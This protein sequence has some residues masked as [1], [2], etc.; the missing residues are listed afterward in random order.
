M[1]IF[2][3]ILWLIT[4]VFLFISFKRDGA[5]T[6]KA[7]KMALNMGKGMAISIF[8]IIL[9]I[10][11][12][13]TFL[14]PYRNCKLCKQA[15]S[16]SGN[17]WFGFTWNNYHH[18]SIYSLSFDRNF[19]RCRSRYCPFSGFLDYSYHGWTCYISTGKKGVWY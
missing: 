14:P 19:S 4:L 17:C 6:K 13:L 1:D 15:V 5:K 11:L 10:G 8:S 7:L 3:I 16:F 12:I 2:T 9:A 18:S